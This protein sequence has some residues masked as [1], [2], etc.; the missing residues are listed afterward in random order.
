MYW[1]VVGALVGFEYV[2]EWFVSWLPFYWEIKTVFLLF[3]SLPQIQ[4]STFIYT[5]YLEPFFAKNETQIDEGI[6]SIQT[7]TFVF[8]QSKLAAIWN[9]LWSVIN[10]TPAN[11][12]GQQ[13][14]GPPL[15]FDAAMGL[16]KAYAPSVL[17]AMQPA[18]KGLAPN[19][20][21]TPSM[22]PSASSTSIPR[23]SAHSRASPSPSPFGDATPP[24]PESVDHI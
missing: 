2:A 1:S 14:Q 17:S 10:K 9:L 21:S 19:A 16:F 11:G 22:A 20:A 12:Q 4:G 8:V 24:L 18:N 7:N 6:T 15:S 23:V 5:N 13:R 3:L